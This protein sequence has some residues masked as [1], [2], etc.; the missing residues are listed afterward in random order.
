MVIEKIRK[1]ID[2]MKELGDGD[3]RDARSALS[4]EDDS[5]REEVKKQLNEIKDSV[6]T[7][8]EALDK[9]MS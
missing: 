7:G 3:L 8:V 4:G 5:M 2:H 9:F 6:D 1:L